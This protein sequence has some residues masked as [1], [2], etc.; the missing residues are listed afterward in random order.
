MGGETLQ[1][2]ASIYTPFSYTIVFI[3]FSFQAS[4]STSL[5]RSIRDRQLASEFHDYQLFCDEDIRHNVW[6]ETKTNSGDI[7][8]DRIWCFFKWT[9]DGS[10][11]FKKL[12]KVSRLILIVSH[13]NIEEKRIL[14]MA[15]KNKACYRPNMDPKK[16]LERL[17]TVKLAT[18][19]EPIHKIK[20]PP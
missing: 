16:T 1:I 12:S 13:S 8:I 5:S 19:N 17:I 18:E 11:Q 6:K 7:P 15:R 14:P 10:Y 2:I 4:K 3:F 9:V 20:L